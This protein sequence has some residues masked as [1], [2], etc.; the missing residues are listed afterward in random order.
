MF[1]FIQ[2]YKAS[3]DCALSLTFAYNK[4]FSIGYEQLTDSR[5]RVLLSVYIF[6]NGVKKRISTHNLPI[7]GTVYIPSRNPT[8]TTYAEAIFEI[9]RKLIEEAIDCNLEYEV[10]SY[11]NGKVNIESIR[12]MYPNEDYSSYKV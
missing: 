7:H 5:E 12:V 9:E 2:S 4:A 1:K 10:H 3:L 6:M 11:L 8:K